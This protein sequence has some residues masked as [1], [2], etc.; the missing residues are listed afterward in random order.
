MARAEIGRSGSPDSAVKVALGQV[1]WPGSA[2]ASV[3]KWDGWPGSATV[4][5]R[6]D[7]LAF[8]MELVQG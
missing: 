8:V 3:L 1:V 4:M 7:C 5:G 2:V 6:A